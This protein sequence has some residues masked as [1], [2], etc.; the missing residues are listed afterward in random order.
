MTSEW[1]FK[2]NLRFILFETA[3]KRRVCQDPRAKISAS[4]PPLAFVE[5]FYLSSRKVAKTI[6]LYKQNVLQL[7]QFPNLCSVSGY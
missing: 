7:E 5:V 3:V 2:E 4:S 6:G 1:T